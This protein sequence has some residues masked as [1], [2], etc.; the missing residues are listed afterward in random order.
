MRYWKG[1]KIDKLE[2]NQVFVFGSNPQGRHGAG[3]AKLAV[4][5][6]AK[7]GVG[8]GLSGKTYALVTKNLKAGYFEKATGIT[9][10][11]DSYRSV[12]PEQIMKNVQDL[13]ECATQHPKLDFLV[14]YQ[15]D[16]WPN[17]TL[18]KSLNGYNAKDMIDIFTKAGKIPENIVFHES[19]QPHIEKIIQ[20]EPPKFN[21]LDDYQN[22]GFTFFFRSE[23]PFSQ[24]HPSL[25]HVKS[26]DDQFVAFVSAEQFMMYCKAKL[27]KDEEIADKIISLNTENDVF[28]QFIH[29]DITKN[30]IIT[31]VDLK[32]KWDGAQ[33]TIK[34]FG[35][36]VKNYNEEVWLKNRVKIVSRGS[37]EKYK[38]NDDL[39]KILLDTNNTIMVEASPYD[40]VY[41]I[42]FNATDPRAKD[43]QLWNGKNLLGKIL[44]H[45]KR[46]FQ[47]ELNVEPEIKK[48]P[49]KL[50]M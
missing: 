2:E 30:D 10:E 39:K 31:R 37:L 34:S 50:K 17:G 47:L 6:G 33:K 28:R 43:P 1:D 38:Q 4:S 46:S 42:G 9:Y 23:S 25:F 41:G 24:W 3:A 35:R 29:G 49:K 13:Y 8:R 12:S 48:E 36:E 19:Y 15:Y 45:L 20:L 22:K 32:S 18:K 16:V 7:Y 5:F 21:Y 27:F 14:I 40:K 11:G 44:T 26:K